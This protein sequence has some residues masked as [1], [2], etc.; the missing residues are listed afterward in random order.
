LPGA[1][2]IPIAFV[3]SHGFRGGSE[4]YLALVLEH[5][6]PAWISMVVCLQ[7]GPLAD[8]LQARGLPVEVVPTGTRLPHM[9][10]AAWRLRRLLRRAGSA[11][12]HA[13]GVKLLS[14]RPRRRSAP[15]IVYLQAEWGCDA[16]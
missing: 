2:A 11:V 6:D 10:A 14:S 7:D 1:A 15:L 13:N 16:C 12:V 4:R 3:S 9:L 8:E 5:L